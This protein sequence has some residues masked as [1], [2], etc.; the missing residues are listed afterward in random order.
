MC[1]IVEIS[2][3]LTFREVKILLQSLGYDSIAGIRMPEEQLT[4]EAVIK[5]LHQMCEK[6]LLRAKEGLFIIDS[7]I[8][9][10]MVCMGQPDETVFY[11]SGDCWS[12]SYFCYIKE[13]LVLV[14]ELYPVKKDVLKLTL[15]NREEY[16]KWKEQMPDDIRRCGSADSGEDL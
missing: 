1:E 15:F 14:S 12:P 4:R 7:R 13:E 3:L 2:E 9:E 11:D 10:M 5:L 8:G 6:G 16:E